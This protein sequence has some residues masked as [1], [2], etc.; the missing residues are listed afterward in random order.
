MKENFYSKA[1]F[2]DLGKNMTDYGSTLNCNQ[3]LPNPTLM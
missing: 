1:Y 3:A 2:I